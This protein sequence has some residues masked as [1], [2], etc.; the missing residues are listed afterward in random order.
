MKKTKSLTG[1]NIIAARAEKAI[2]ESLP[3]D[4]KTLRIIGKVLEPQ[5]LKRIGIA[6]VGGSVLVSLVSSLGRDRINRIETARELR[7]E[8]MPIQKKLDELEA[9][10]TVLWQQNEELKLQLAKLESLYSENDPT[11]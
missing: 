6:A 11:A 1:N 7:K 8:L 9:Q 3:V 4:Q 2:M 5:N 10:N